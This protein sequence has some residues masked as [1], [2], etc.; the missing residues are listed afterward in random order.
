M[1]WFVVT[2]LLLASGLLTDAVHAQFLPNPNPTLAKP[3]ED[4][5][6]KS[7]PAHL[8]RLPSNPLSQAQLGEIES[9]LTG[10]HATA[11]I[12]S[13]QRLLDF[14]ADFLEVRDHQ[15]KGSFLQRVESLLRA[16]RADYQRQF[17]DA[18][19]QQLDDIRKQ[20][21]AGRLCDFIRRY[22]M[23]TA[24][25]AALQELARLEQ[26]EGNLAAAARTLELWSQHPDCEDRVKPLSTAITLLVTSGER[27][28]ARALVA[29]HRE[30]LP[31]E[32]A[33]WVLASAV[34]AMSPADA[35]L[36]FWQTTNGNAQHAGSA[37]FAPAVG[38]PVWTAPLLH[39]YDFEVLA[40]APDLM[41]RLLAENEKLNRDLEHNLRQT[42][43]RVLFPAGRPL[44]VGDLVI[45]AGQGSVKAF[46]LADGKLRGNSAEIDEAFK[47]LAIHSFSSQDLSDASRT[48]KRELLARIRGW[49][50]LTSFSLSSDGSAVYAVTD[51]QLVGTTSARRIQ[52]TTQ[53][54]PLL[55]RRENRLL[56]LDLA[57]G[58]KQRWPQA[59]I[60][61]DI[62]GPST[63]QAPRAIYYF[64]PPLPVDGK[65]YV[66]GEELGQIQ[67]M[68]LDPNSG[69]ILWTVGLLNPD[70]S[71]M[72]DMVRRMSG[73]MPA[74]ASGLIIC[75][76]GEDAI[77]AVDPLT[78]R[79]L[80]LHGYSPEL[81]NR[82]RT[83]ALRRNL[84]LPNY[85]TYGS[86]DELLDE[87]RWYDARVLT[88]GD[89]VIHTPSD[90]DVL[91]ALNLHDGSPVWSLPRMQLLYAP[92]VC[93]DK[94]IL[95]ARQHVLAVN[96]SDGKPAWQQP[97]PI[98]P[99][100]GRGVR[101][102][103]TF[104]QPLASGEI[105]II[106]LQSGR[107]LA[108]LPFAEGKVPGN[109]VAANGML[110]SQSASELIALPTEQSL[111][112]QLQQL[113][114]AN[115]KDAEALALRGE[116]R[117]QHGNLSTG[118]DDLQTALALKE[119][120]TIRK[121][122]NATLLEGLRSNFNEYRARSQDIERSLS[123]QDRLQYLVLCVEGLAANGE[124]REALEHALTLLTESLKIPALHHPSH[125]W[126]AS[127]ER[128]ALAR[129]GQLLEGESPEAAA[130]HA[131]LVNWLHTR[132]G[133]EIDRILLSAPPA[134]VAEDV[135][136][137]M[138]QA[139][140]PTVAGFRLRE[141]VLEPLLHSEQDSVRIGA[142]DELASL[143]LHSKNAD[144]LSQAIQRLNTVPNQPQAAAALSAW[145]T[146]SAARKL[147]DETVR[148]PNEL[149]LV[150]TQYNQNFS[151][152]T[153]LRH[154][155]PRSAEL[156]GWTFAVDQAAINV[157][158]LNQHGE[159]VADV[160]TNQMLLRYGAET[161]FNN[162]VMTAGH[163]AAIVLHDRFI[164]VDCLAD[165]P[166]VRFMGVYSLIEMPES[167][168]SNMLLDSRPGYRSDTAETLG[169]L[170]GTV[171]PLSLSQ[172]CY[173][174]GTDLIAIDPLSGREQWRRRDLSLGAEVLGDSEVVM[175]REQGGL[176]FKLFRATDGAHLRD[177]PFQPL[178][179]AED[180]RDGDWGRLQPA[181]KQSGLA[182]SLNMWDPVTDQ[183]VWSRSLELRECWT[184]VNGRDIAFLRS[185]G[186][187][188]IV[189]GKTGIVQFETT[190]PQTQPFDAFRV[191]QFPDQWVVAPERKNQIQRALTISPFFMEPTATLE[192]VSLMAN[193]TGTMSA[194]DRKTGAL[195]W[196]LAV[197]NQKLMTELPVLWPVLAMSNPSSPGG[198]MS[199][200][201]LNRHTGKIIWKDTSGRDGSGLGFL[202]KATLRQAQLRFGTT[203]VVLD[204]QGA[205]PEDPREK[206]PA[207][208]P[209]QQE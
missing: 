154:L 133:E 181:L 209:G 110:V 87:D 14:E 191:L 208:L 43:P 18:A 124:R 186:E 143:A 206:P 128:W 193:V 160:P 99:P 57:Q 195:Q 50:D 48:E 83:Q 120:P 149:R 108:R 139:R 204:A 62:F 77:C 30:T 207:I 164:L 197:E 53:K 88:A 159:H 12:A 179:M 173:T 196:Q 93:D 175:V 158:I 3:R 185:T 64:G 177:V 46:R 78:R 205:P 73:I 140:Q 49:R 98:T 144:L 59:G 45:A 107:A 184:P 106:D 80:W 55:P 96:L 161:G 157:S 86:P 113:L 122:A 112:V 192:E 38:A 67:L 148:W 189:D 37:T 118:L 75:P 105:A 71:L 166:A 114:A 116:L 15:I 163:V 56:A 22:S 23:T 119:N 65:L 111:Q 142:T 176:Q 130:L 29:R 167:S 95:V 92:T 58:L 84:G 39:E 81:E 132:T 131:R 102:G 134:W 188:T 171:G 10:E 172:L 20:Q 36:L 103:N 183:L 200:L 1:R 190:L 41:E 28:A 7:E 33:N 66:L 26:D 9:E 101:M 117:L 136:L 34:A 145:N 11:A 8:R 90:R 180:R 25:G 121:V 109:L 44:I 82:A 51:C 21:D 5:A 168:D 85:V 17:G 79:I 138:L 27:S 16:H 52:S 60:E 74:Y 97:V 91:V 89:R 6:D 169:G 135:R 35:P 61:D 170:C 152:I 202:G 155:G 182:R 198:L 153:Q 203:W 40:S 165:A 2:L 19:R 141:A 129:I 194:I 100:S 137:A 126:S 125:V 76:V 4:D 150:R 151:R 127:M 174:V 32:A 123:P 54:H 115:S 146:N 13:L 201:V 72:L 24:G 63:Q 70:T 42:D 187:F 199:N 156:E 94:L 104:L 31:A 147:L 178:L 68:E 69:E 47:H 162:Y